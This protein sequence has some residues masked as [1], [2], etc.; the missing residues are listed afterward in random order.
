VAKAGML[1]RKPVTKVYEAF[2]DPAI[3]TRFWFTHSSGML[4]AGKKIRW[5]WEM[6]G[7]T[8]EVKV[9][10]LEKDKRILIEWGT[11]EA[12]TTLELIFSSRPDNTTFVS[13]TDAGFSGDGDLVAEQAM[14][15]ASGLA[16]VLANLKGYLEHGIELYLIADRFPDQLVNRL[17]SIQQT[18]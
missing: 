18:H 3:T 1:I 11:D 6:Y 5:E 16:L 2:I 14:Y 12:P 8:V 10:T 15:S 4:E 9:L 17:P 13:I 7:V